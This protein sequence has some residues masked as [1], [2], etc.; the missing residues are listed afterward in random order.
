MR[1]PASIPSPAATAALRSCRGGAQELTFQ[2]D[3]QD[4]SGRFMISVPQNTEPQPTASAVVTYGKDDPVTLP[5]DASV[6]LS[7]VLL[8][9]NYKRPARRPITNT[10]S[11]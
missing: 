3:E 5:E 10:P 7:T 9:A 1:P 8:Q 2:F 6:A 4:G 11:T